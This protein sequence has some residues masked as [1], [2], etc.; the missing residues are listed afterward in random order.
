MYDVVGVKAPHASRLVTASKNPLTSA[1]FR[2]TE[3]AHVLYT[4]SPPSAPCEQ[5]EEGNIRRHTAGKRQESP[6]GE[7]CLRSL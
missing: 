4:C 3:Q 6:Q 5:T 7:S 2:A 1:D